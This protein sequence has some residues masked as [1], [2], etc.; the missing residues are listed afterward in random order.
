MEDI[1]VNIITAIIMLAPLVG[2]GIVIYI[3]MKKYR[4]KH[5]KVKKPSFVEKAADNYEKKQKL[6]AEAK[7]KEEQEKKEAEAIIKAEE[8]RKANTR[9][10]R[11][12][13]HG[14]N[15]K[16]E[17]GEEILKLIRRISDYYRDEDDPFRMWRKKD[18]DYFQE[19]EIDEF[20]H[21][22]QLAGDLKVTDFD[23]EPAV[24]V[25]LFDEEADK[26]Q[27]IGWIPKDQAADV[28]DMLRKHKC[29]VDIEID[30]GKR[31]IYDGSTIE[32]F[33]S[34][35]FVDAIISYEVLSK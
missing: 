9:S 25:Y 1:I 12:H 10:Y 28:A 30:G 19:S 24:K 5:P 7:A 6:K 18:Y 3:L 35:I 33:D 14:M 8:E 11:Y 20:S 32:T 34:N 29:Q 26:D 23:G 2:I 15:Y 27:H 16:N 13:V 31:K 4:Q 17:T 21:L 22:G